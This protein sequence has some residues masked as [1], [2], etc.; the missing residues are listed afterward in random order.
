[1]EPAKYFGSIYPAFQLLRF[2]PTPTG[3]D[4][5]EGLVLR[6]RKAAPEEHSEGDDD[7]RKR[8]ERICSDGGLADRLHILC[9]SRSSRQI[10]YLYTWRSNRQITYSMIYTL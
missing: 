5:V 1:M 9:S 3:R 4:L 8:D 10:T 6:L 7:D 2:A